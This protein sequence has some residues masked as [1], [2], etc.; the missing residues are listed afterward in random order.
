MFAKILTTMTCG[1]KRK[2]FEL[3]E[4]DALLLL[5]EQVRKLEGVQGVLRKKQRRTKLTIPLY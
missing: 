2:R 1:L 5:I 4:L 3:V